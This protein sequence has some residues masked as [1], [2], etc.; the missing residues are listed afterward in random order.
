MNQ[1]IDDK[2]KLKIQNEFKNTLERTSDNPVLKAFVTWQILSE[3]LRTILDAEVHTQ[4]FKNIQPIVL[5]D[6]ILLLQTETQF[7]AQ[8]INT[9]YQELVDTVILTHDRKYS[10]FFIA[11]KKKVTSISKSA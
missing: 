6:N 11:P 1:A 8:W 9:H 7:A 4:W 10:C 3:Q 5:K 2:L